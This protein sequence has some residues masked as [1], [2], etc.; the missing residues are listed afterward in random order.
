MLGSHGLIKAFGASYGIWISGN[1]A[2]D[3]LGSFSDKDMD[4]WFW[5]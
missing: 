1:F 4:S 5:S 2:I 3:V